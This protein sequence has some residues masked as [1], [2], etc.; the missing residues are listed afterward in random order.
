LKVFVYLY[1][2]RR[3]LTHP[4]YF[5]QVTLMW[6][7][8]HINNPCAL[9][10]FIYLYYMTNQ[11]IYNNRAAA[12]RAVNNKNW[13]NKTI[14]YKTPA[15]N[16]VTR[17]VETVTIKERR[18]MGNMMG[19]MNVNVEVK[20]IVNTNNNIEAK[21]VKKKENRKA[22]GGA[23]IH[24]NRK[25]ANR[26]VINGLYT[27]KPTISYYKND[28]SGEV[29]TRRIITVKKRVW[30]NSP[31]G[32]SSWLENEHVQIISNDPNNR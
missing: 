30:K 14:K 23:I 4:I 26:A 11:K 13:K 29:I 31:N 28:G 16:V 25:A 12:N 7:C 1:D 22:H 17:N 15:G 18:F 19:M 20:K 8:A 6:T 21:K 10:L 24:T 2:A 3:D 27:G 32:S 9:L 5:E